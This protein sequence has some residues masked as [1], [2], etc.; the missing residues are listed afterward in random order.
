MAVD[1]R[2]KALGNSTGFMNLDGIEYREYQYNIIQS[3][4]RHGNSLVVLPTGLGKTFIGAAVIADCLSK[5]GKAMILAPTK[6]LAEQHH[7]TISK[8][9]K[10]RDDELFLLVGSAKKKERKEKENTAK[11]VVATPQTVANDMR[12]GLLSLDGFRVVV[13]DECHK[14]VGKYA[15]TYIANESVLKG[16]DILGLTASPGGDRDKIGKLVSSLSIKHIEARVS[17]DPDVEAYVMPKYMHVVNVDLSSRVKQLSE[18][19]KPIMA[20]NLLILSRMGLNPFKKADSIPKGRL[21]QMG[22]D[23][24]KLQAKNYKFAAMASYVK[25]LN[26][27]HMYDLLQSEGIYPFTAYIESIEQRDKRSRAVEQLMRNGNIVAAR[28]FAIEA[29]KNG[30][31]HPKVLAVLDV[32]KDHRGKNCI[33]FA[34]YRSTI[35]ML[36]EFLRNNGFTAMPFVGKKDGVTQDQQKRVIE[37][38]RARKFD[39][40]VASSIGEE[41]LDIPNVDLV[42][43]YE[44][45][46]NEIRNIQR[47]G[48]TGRF[49]SGDV[50]ILVAK[51][52]KDQIYMYI[53]GRRERKMFEIIKSINRGL[54]Q[55]RTP[56]ESIGAGQSRLGT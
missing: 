25:L 48:R 23:I 10:L 14:A 39:V 19:L 22:R 36:I 16:V 47:R 54:A 5:G 56:G 38:F 51:D 26:L 32:L 37:D 41:G 18:L 17:T 46:P 31:E 2:W 11:V 29:Q 33:I 40:L 30:E 7:G 13:I 27:S 49:R 3:V 44:P 15:Y 12:A 4:L 28:Q 55:Q 34:Q 21:I 6:P 42:I 20:E 8:M 35:K 52:T 24:E 50:Y 45:I 9:L 1:D 53:S 43:F